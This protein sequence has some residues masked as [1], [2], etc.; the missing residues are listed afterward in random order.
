MPGHIVTGCLVWASAS[1]MNQAF[2]FPC[3]WILLCML[4]GSQMQTMPG[5][6]HKEEGIVPSQPSP[7]SQMHHLD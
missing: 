3:H 2:G 7:E 1:D 5:R 4:A 6:I